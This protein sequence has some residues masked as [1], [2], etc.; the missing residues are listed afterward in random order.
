M[1]EYQD[2]SIPERIQLVEDI[3]DSIAV[4]CKDLPV[5]DAQKAELDKRLGRMATEGTDDIDA[6]QFLSELKSKL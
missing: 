4:H 5:T 2:L 1:A 6:K 3:W